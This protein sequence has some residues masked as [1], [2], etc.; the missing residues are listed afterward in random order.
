MPSCRG[1]PESVILLCV[2]SWGSA[3]CF[4]TCISICAKPCW[5]IQTL[6]QQDA[7]VTLAWIK[8]SINLI[9][10]AGDMEQEK[11][12]QDFQFHPII[13]PTVHIVQMAPINLLSHHLW[14]L[15]FHINIDWAG[16]ID[17][18]YVKPTFSCVAAECCRDA[19]C[20]TIYFRT[21]FFSCRI[22]SCSAKS[23]SPCMD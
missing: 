4:N 21:R 15:H 18:F 13:F 10:K 12:T 1:Q 9:K 5:I 20:F 3:D 22:P 17:I 8:R 23:I 14:A 16:E 2:Q 11:W 7:S 6:W 19:G